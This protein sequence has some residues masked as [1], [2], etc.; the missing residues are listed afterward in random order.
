MRLDGWVQAN[1][2][3]RPL[4]QGPSAGAFS[5]RSAIVCKSLDLALRTVSD[6]HIHGTASIIGE[7]DS[8]LSRMP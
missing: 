8:E 4:L 2:E 6:S 5:T 3:V 7:A 1:L